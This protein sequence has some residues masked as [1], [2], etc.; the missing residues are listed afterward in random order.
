MKQLNTIWD[1][2]SNKQVN[3]GKISKLNIFPCSLLCL[4]IYTK[5]NIDQQN[6]VKETIEII[7]EK[8]HESTPISHA[9]CIAKL[10]IFFNFNVCIFE[11]FCIEK[12][13]D[14]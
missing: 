10:I 2:L 11:V 7:T 13:S 6:M 9:S 8:V 3:K 1:K 5:E 4:N 12:W 14:L